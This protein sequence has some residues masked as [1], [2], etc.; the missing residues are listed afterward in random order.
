MHS[1]SYLVRIHTLDIRED[2]KSK[3]QTV[4]YFKNYNMCIA[5]HVDI[6]CHVALE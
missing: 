5:N 2:I 3:T 1:E 4:C 6:D